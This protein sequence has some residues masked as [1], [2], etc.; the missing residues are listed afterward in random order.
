MYI[1]D[2][3]SYQEMAEQWEAEYLSLKEFEESAPR[4]HRE[5]ELDANFYADM[6]HAYQQWKY[7]RELAEEQANADD[8][9]E[10][11]SIICRSQGLPRFCC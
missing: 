1:Y 10:E 8:P 11:Y 5:D 4:T 6:R 7:Y 3:D 9:E 2:D